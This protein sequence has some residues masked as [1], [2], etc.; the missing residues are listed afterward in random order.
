M[1]LSHCLSFWLVMI[2]LETWGGPIEA[3]S[4]QTCQ[5]S[6]K[7]ICHRR[8][9]L[10]GVGHGQRCSVSTPGGVRDSHCHFALKEELG[11][12]LDTVRQKLDQGPQTGLEQAEEAL[13]KARLEE[14]KAKEELEATKLV[15]PPRPLQEEPRNGIVFLSFAD[16]EG[17]IGLFQELKDKRDA[18]G[19]GEPASKK[20]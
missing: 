3:R 6:A 20:P 10:I 16:V 5:R 1:P 2:A 7:Q 12:Q 17:L 19:V 14:T 9:Q 11:S 4:H 15:T 8:R 18:P 13:E